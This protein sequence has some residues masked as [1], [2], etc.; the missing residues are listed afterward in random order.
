M[1][2]RQTNYIYI[3]EYKYLNKNDKIYNLVLYFQH[4]IYKVQLKN[5]IISK[6]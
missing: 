1:F 4:I 6:F 3:F 2:D 5:N